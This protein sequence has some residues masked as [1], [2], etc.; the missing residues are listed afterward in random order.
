MLKDLEIKKQQEIYQL[1]EKG[2]FRAAKI[3]YDQCKDLPFIQ[4][5]SKNKRNY[6]ASLNPANASSQNSNVG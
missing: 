4:G 5:K 6:S 2:D 3:V 1:L